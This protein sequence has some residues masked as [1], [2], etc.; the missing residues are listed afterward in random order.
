MAAHH[1]D[2]ASGWVTIVA[3]PK[4]NGATVSRMVCGLL[5]SQPEVAGYDFI[6]DLTD[7]TGEASNADVE[8]IAACYATHRVDEARTKYSLLAT[9]DP[10]FHLWAAAMDHFF[11]D[12]RHLVTRTVALAEARLRDLRAGVSAA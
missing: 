1:I 9:S 7:W 2:R 3:G 5:E 4:D 10:N 11:I 8:A 12:R 6:F